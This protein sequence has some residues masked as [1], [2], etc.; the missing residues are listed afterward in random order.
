MN[1]MRE[2]KFRAW[3]TTAGSGRMV[4]WEELNKYPCEA[5]FLPPNREVALM[6]YIGREDVNGEEVCEGDIVKPIVLNSHLEGVVCVVEYAGHSFKMI[7]VV[8]DTCES[9]I[10]WYH[11]F[12]IIGNKHENSEL[13]K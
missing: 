9:N 10:I 13:L 7:P 12:E 2:I 5:V 4:F 11:S 1:E 6:Q 3:D 8:G